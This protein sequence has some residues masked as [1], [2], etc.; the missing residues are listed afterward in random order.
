[1]TKE[2]IE[3]I[4]EKPEKKSPKKT[5]IR[6][7]VDGRVLTSDAITSQIPFFVLVALLAILYIANRYHAEKLV[8]QATRLENQ[9]RELRAEAISSAAELTD[10]SKRSALINLIGRKGL[11]LKESVVPPR[12]IIADEK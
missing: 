11:D 7:F 6:E 4:D 2:R 5:T 9:V 10:S 8:R 1:M 3:F 12:K